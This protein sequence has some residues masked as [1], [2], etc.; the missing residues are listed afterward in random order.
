[1]SRPAHSFS[2][3]L[4]LASLIALVLSIGSTLPNSTEA[5]QSAKRLYSPSAW[6]L[7]PMQG[8]DVNEKTF[9]DILNHLDQ[10]N[11]PITV[12]HFDFD[13]WETCP[14]N[15]SFAWSDS[16]LQRMR[17]HNPPIRGLF[18]LLPLIKKECG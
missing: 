13:S 18:W 2:F 6:I 3:V 16:I 10:N 9:N 5:A 7:G 15:A 1:M 8:R 4:V 17:T 12:F 11:I 14:N